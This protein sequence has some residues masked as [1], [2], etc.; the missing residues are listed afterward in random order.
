MTGPLVVLAILAATVGLLGSPLTDYAFGS[1]LGRARGRSNPATGLWPW[2]LAVA[3]GGHRLRVADVHAQAASARPTSSRSV[4]GRGLLSDKFWVRRGLRA[5]VV[6]PVIAA[7]R[8]CTR[9]DHAL[10]DGVVS[11]RRA[12]SAWPSAPCWQSSTARAS[13]ALSTGSAG[14]VDE[15]GETCAAMQT[16]N[17]QT[18]LLLLVLRIVVLVVV[19]AR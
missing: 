5:G 3:I 2:R 13:T 7:S 15:A 12:G 9:V 19:F 10:V 17:V 11:G 16:G 1:F 18:Y 14:R 6:R 8:V 4:L